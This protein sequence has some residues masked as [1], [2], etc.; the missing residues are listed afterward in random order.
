MFLLF[1]QLFPSVNPINKFHHMVHY[2][3]IIRENGPPMRYWCMRYEAYHNI[4]K[5]VAHVNCNFTNIAKSVAMHLQTVS[6]AAIL[7]DNLFHSNDFILGPIDRAR[8]EVPFPVDFKLI[9]WVKF[10]GREYRFRS[11]IVIRHSYVT[12]C[13]FPQFGIIK[14]IAVN[15]RKLIFG[16]RSCRTVRFD[17]HFHSFEIDYDSN[18]EL[19]PLNFDDVPDCEPLWILQNF[20][21]DD[22]RLFV[23]P[24]RW[25]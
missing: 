2:P 6:C 24:R 9:K 14:K 21:V 16:V 13:G 5:R 7:N 25:V 4:C 12:E 17:D 3:A 11:V 8:C 1:N 23:S 22:N 10:L 20:K 15:E 19:L 18:D